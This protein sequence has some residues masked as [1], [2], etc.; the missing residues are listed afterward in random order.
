MYET[1]KILHRDISVS[2]IMFRREQGPSGSVQGVLCDWDLAYDPEDPNPPEQ[3]TLKATPDSDTSKDEIVI[4]KHDKDHVG[5]CY[6]TGT[7]PFMALDLLEAGP[8]PLHLYR[9]D[10]ESFFWVLIWFCAVFDPETHTFGHLKNWENSDL[11]TVGVN[12]RHFLQ[13]GTV[14]K[15]VFANIS[16]RYQPLKLTWIRRLL[17]RFEIINV[18]KYAT[19]KQIVKQKEWA[20]DSELPEDED[21]ADADSEIGESAH[22]AEEIEAI[23]KSRNETIA[24]LKFM[25]C[26]G[27]DVSDEQPDSFH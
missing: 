22:H 6:R 7:G 9:H 17:R 25:K 15:A 23:Q 12:K 5:P 4:E 3:K 14:Q 21:W 8:V 10:L 1:S 2:N 20:E 19:L 26:L 13:D 18:I 11:V 16:P 24:Y 27:V